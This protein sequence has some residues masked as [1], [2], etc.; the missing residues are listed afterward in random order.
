MS[1]SSVSGGEIV[2]ARTSPPVAR[3]V[4]RGATMTGPLGRQ[5]QEVLMRRLF[6]AFA[7]VLA[8]GAV[9]SGCTKKTDTASTETSS[10]SLLATNPV[11]QP[12]GNLTPQEQ[13]QPNQKS[14]EAPPTPAATETHPRAQTSS[15]PRHT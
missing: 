2:M 6:L 4:S 15:H 14:E 10:D 1:T 5:N 8:V 9:A 3:L 7:V 13:Y 12:Q 11:E